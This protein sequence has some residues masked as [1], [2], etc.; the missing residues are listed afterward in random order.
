LL[1]HIDSA[2]RA[3]LEASLIGSREIRKRDRTIIDEQIE[4]RVFDCIPS[5]TARKVIEKVWGLNRLA[6]VGFRRKNTAALLYKYFADMAQAM[7]TINTRLKSG[8][9]AFIVIGDNRTT[10]GDEEVRIPSSK[11]LQEIGLSLGWSLQEPIP[12]TVTRENHLHAQNSIT[13]NDI[14]RFTKPAR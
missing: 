9:S 4:N 8:G 10:A 12:I 1:L 13:C 6:D 11:C 2:G 14:I 3:G 7:G 5:D